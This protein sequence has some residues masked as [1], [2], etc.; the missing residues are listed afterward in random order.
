MR[1]TDYAAA[2]AALHPHSYLM[3]ELVDSSDAK[4][5][6]VAAYR[7]RAVNYVNAFGRQVDLC[8]VGNEINGEWLGTT[9]QVVAKMTPPIRWSPGPADGRR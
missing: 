6:S 5:Y 4:A 9:S 1:P 8:E 7:Q 2:I 3:G